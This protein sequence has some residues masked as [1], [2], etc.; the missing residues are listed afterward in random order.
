VLG[1]P[2]TASVYMD[3][4]EFVVA[5]RSFC[6]AAFGGVADRLAPGARRIVERS[7]NH[8]EH[9][10][11]IGAVYPDSWIV[12]IIRDGRDVARSLVS[13]PWGPRSVAEAA[14]L[15]ARSIRSARAAAQHL[16]RYREVR[17]EELLKNPGSGLAEVFRF[18]DL[19][20]DTGTVNGVL[21]EAGVAYNTDQRRPEIGDGKWRSEW[22]SRDLA[23]FERVAGDVR[24]A[25]GYAEAAATGTRTGQLLRA[26]KRRVLPGDP[27][28]VPPEP[29]VRPYL[30]M[31]ARQRRAAPG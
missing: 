25:L 12:H 26:A 11:L 24:S 14:S 3:R 6:D 16:T 30:P 1:S 17:Y 5:A 22:S 2:S 20:A 19:D 23:S 9:L 21:A 15:W 28:A 27:G 13:Q 31:E 29:L 4:S 10:D 7:P 8:V 18:L